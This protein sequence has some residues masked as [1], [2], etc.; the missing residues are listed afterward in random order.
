M[1]IPS[2]PSL[3]AFASVASKDWSFT[4]SSVR[5]T[6]ISTTARSTSRPSRCWRPSAPR[7]QSFGGASF[8]GETTSPRRPNSRRKRAWFVALGLALQVATLIPVVVTAIETRQARELRTRELF[9]ERRARVRS[10]AV[11]YFTRSGN[12]ALAA[13]HIANRLDAQLHRLEAPDYEL[14]LRGWADAMFDARATEA[15]I[16]PRTIDLTGV[17]TVYLGAAHLALQ[18]RTADLGIRREQPL[19]RQACRAVYHP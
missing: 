3:T 6:W 8:L 2:V 5:T 12:T 19:R 15:T 17:D 11:V 10:A 14:G 16:S 18:P 7:S 4:S 9:E 13:R 1:R